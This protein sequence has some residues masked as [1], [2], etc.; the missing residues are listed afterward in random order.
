M[1]EDYWTQMTI[2]QIREVERYDDNGMDRYEFTKIFRD[3]L[4]LVQ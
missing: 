2:G 1:L 3:F 4:S